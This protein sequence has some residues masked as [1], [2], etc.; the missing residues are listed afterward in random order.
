MR[1]SLVLLPA[2]LAALGG[3]VTAERQTSY[4]EAMRLTVAELQQGDLKAARISLDLAAENACDDC[5]RQ[6][7]ED[8]SHLIAG[9]E[10]YCAGDRIAA[11]M[12]WSETESSVIRREISSREAELGVAIRSVEGGVR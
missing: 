10:A 1:V 5:D 8:L 9:A 7:A 12:E 3:C 4:D 6:K 11:G 2:L